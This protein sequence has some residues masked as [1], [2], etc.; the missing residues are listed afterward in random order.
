MAS[1]RWSVIEYGTAMICGWGVA[2]IKNEK[3]KD[4]KHAFHQSIAFSQLLRY[5]I[6]V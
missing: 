1:V 6:H 5:F 3:M 4:N 2:G